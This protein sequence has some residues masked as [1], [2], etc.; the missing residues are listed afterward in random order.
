MASF[1]SAFQ[2]RYAILDWTDGK[3]CKARLPGTLSSAPASALKCPAAMTQASAAA[4][5]GSHDGRLGRAPAG[6]AERSGG[7]RAPVRTAAVCSGHR[8]ATPSFASIVLVFKASWL[9]SHH[10]GHAVSSLK[11]LI[12]LLSFLFLGVPLAHVLGCATLQ[13]LIGPHCI[14]EALEAWKKV[15][16][17][18]V[19]F[20]AVGISI[21]SEAASE[22][23]AACATA[24][25]L[26]VNLFPAGQ[27][28][29]P[30]QLKPTHLWSTVCAVFDA[31]DLQ[32]CR[33]PRRCL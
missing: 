9:V 27:C 16:N 7:H 25:A 26:I 30:H 8:Q 32:E 28:S 4:E 6:A 3:P 12:H 33:R 31:T 15:E 10:R 22:A 1:M 19:S 2:R 21:D 5:P 24:Q 20:T 17:S 14:A 18:I 29:L 23:S 13:P 11:V